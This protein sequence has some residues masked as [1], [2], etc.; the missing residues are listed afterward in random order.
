MSEEFT[1][2]NKSSN[3]TNVISYNNKTSNVHSDYLGTFLTQYK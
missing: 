3:D 1:N 2:I